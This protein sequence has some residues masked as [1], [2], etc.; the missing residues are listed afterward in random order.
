MNSVLSQDVK[1][2]A[3]KL[4]KEWSE[5]SFQEIYED[6]TEFYD[7]SDTLSMRITAEKLLKEAKYTENPEYYIMG[8]HRLSDYFRVI[9]KY[10]EAASLMD[11]AIVYL[12]KS[13]NFYKK[14]QLFLVNGSLNRVLG[15]YEKAIEN[16]LLNLEIAKKDKNEFLELMTK[17][18]IAKIKG[19]VYDPKEA[20]EICLESIQLIEDSQNPLIREHYDKFLIDLWT[21]LANKYISIYDYKTALYYCNQLIEK[22]KQTNDSNIIATGI[23]GLSD[24][25]S[26]TAE[27]DKTLSYLETFDNLEGLTNKVFYQPFVHLFYARIYFYTNEYSKALTALEK[28]DELQKER[29]FDFF[30]LQEK[31]VLYAKTY[32]SLGEIDE[33]LTY[34][35]KANNVY[36]NNIERK[37]KLSQNIIERYNLADFKNEISVLSKRT[38]AQ[39]RLFW[40]ATI[41]LF[42]GV[43]IFMAYFN[44]KQKKNKEKFNRLLKQIDR[45]QVGIRNKFYKDSKSKD[46]LDELDILEKKLFF[47]DDSITLY[48]LAKMLNTNTTYLSRVINMEKKCSFSKYLTN[49]RITYAIHKLRTDKKFRMYSIEALY[50]ESGFKSLNPFLNAFKATTNLYPSYFIRRLNKHDN[51]SS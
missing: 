3:L 31:Y 8:Y 24:I 30:V 29:S 45:Q 4:R 32:Q 21:T 1:E 11:T 28:I 14:T 42:L 7:T 18:P 46:I 25:Y 6:F 12:D 2:R 48:Q 38:N 44:L 35:N 26:L 39:R 5:K 51:L 16:Y 13:P 37:S 49:L 34:F 36:R 33:S 9:E 43:I 10:D 23:I 17:I 15:R 20:I 22:G 19:Q 41:L 50:K 40:K 47:L 27:Y